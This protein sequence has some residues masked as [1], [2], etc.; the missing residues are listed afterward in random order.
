MTKAVKVSPV[1][2]DV[3]HQAIHAHAT[4]V[5]PGMMMKVAATPTPD[6]WEFPPSEVVFRVGR[7]QNVCVFLVSHWPLS[8]HV[9][10]WTNS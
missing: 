3:K 5:R 1:R 2:L 6:G 10:R 7:A 4:Y 8:R 9:G